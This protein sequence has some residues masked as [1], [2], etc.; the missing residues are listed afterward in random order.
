MD[1][2]LRL[3]PQRIG[4]RHKVRFAGCNKIDQCRQNPRIGR[5]GAQII[6]IEPGQRQES[7]AKVVIRHDMREQL[8][9]QYEWVRNGVNTFVAS[10]VYDTLSADSST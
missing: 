7:R 8:Q 9:T 5:P 1:D 4:R 2:R 3:H 10:H 6:G